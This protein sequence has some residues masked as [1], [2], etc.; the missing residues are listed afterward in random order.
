VA[1]GVGVGVVGVDDLL[2]PHAIASAP[3]A[4]AHAA[5]TRNR[6]FTY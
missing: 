3:A 5:P 6:F 1:E 4:A 2:E